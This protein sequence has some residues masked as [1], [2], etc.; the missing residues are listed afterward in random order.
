MTTG[1]FPGRPALSQA[2]RGRT[3]VRHGSRG[4]WAAQRGGAVR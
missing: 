1:P 2:A 4:A 3:P